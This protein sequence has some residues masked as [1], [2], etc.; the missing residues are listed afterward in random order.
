MGNSRNRI[1]ITISLVIGFAI[2]AITWSFFL[3]RA[4]TSCSDGEFSYVN[5][6]LAD[7]PEKQVIKKHDYIVLKSKI[8]EF[9]KLKTQAGDISAV[10]VYF[11]DLQN[12]PTMGIRED[13]KFIPASL[14]KLPVLLTYLR[15]SEENPQLLNT[16]LVYHTDK[17]IVEGAQWITPPESIK[18]QMPY[19]IDDLLKRMITYSDNASAEVLKSY[20]ES[21]YPKQNVLYQTLLDLGIVNPQNVG[22]ETISVKSYASIF[23]TLYNVS[24]LNTTQAS[25]QALSLLASTTFNQ[26]I[27]AGVPA[28]IVVAHKYGERSG[29]PN[30]K[31][32]NQLH[33]CGIVYYPQ[34]PYLIC[35]MTRGNNFQKLA[36][37]IQDISRMIYEEVDSRRIQ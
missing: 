36:Q 6:E 22:D 26:G 2:G 5:C 29:I 19:S 32:H 1:I 30:S 33:D 16:K 34:N 23:R 4:K 24:F 18:E 28:E 25:T 8:D 15:L 10:S 9:V 7:L 11:R 17:H 13:A 12:G 3:A 37:T 14:L 20:L 27:K 21:L 35:I 31:D